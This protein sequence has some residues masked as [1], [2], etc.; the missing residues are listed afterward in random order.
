[1]ADKLIASC[2]IKSTLSSNDCQIQKV[3]FCSR[4]E[5]FFDAAHLRGPLRTL[6][7]TKLLYFYSKSWPRVSKASGFYYFLTGPRKAPKRPPRD[8]QEAAKT[9]GSPGTPRD[10]PRD[11]QLHTF[12]VFFIAKVGL[13]CQQ[14]KVI[15]I[16]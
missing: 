3:L 9:R 13:R 1:M 16:V 4:M 12:I 6:S 15:I 10:P 14:A 8:L 7:C 5:H 11:P 2:L